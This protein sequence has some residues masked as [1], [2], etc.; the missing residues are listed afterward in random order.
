MKRFIVI[1]LAAAL[2]AACSLPCAFA[3]PED[4]QGKTLSDF[5]VKTING[6]TFTLSESLKTHDLVLINLWATWCGPC[7]MEFPYLETAWE[8]YGSRVDVIALSIESSDSFDVL[9][10]FANEYGLNFPI[11]RDETNIFGMIGGTAIPTTLIVDRD[12][13]IVTVEIGSKSSVDEFTNLFDSL[14]SAYPDKTQNTERCVLYFRDSDGN[15]VRGVTVAFC[16]GEYDPIE[17]DESGR[18]SFDGDPNDYHVHLLGVP[19]GY[20]L[21]WEQMYVFGDSFELTV[22]LHTD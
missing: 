16:N 21:P 14:L 7:R 1:L 8:R 3:A 18:V 13:R 19:D 15:P 22:T 4:W 6:D 20:K 9:R 2:F 17:T 5:S 10:R 12:M 11:G